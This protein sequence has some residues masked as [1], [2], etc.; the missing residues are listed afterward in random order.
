M[1]AD[2]LRLAFRPR[3]A[4]V[5]DKKNFHTVVCLDSVRSNLNKSRTGRSR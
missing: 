4:R 2:G 3:L 1:Q 5:R